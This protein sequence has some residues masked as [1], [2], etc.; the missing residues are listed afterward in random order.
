MNP[1]LRHYKSAAYAM[2]V[3]VCL[4]MNVRADGITIRDVETWLDQER[5]YLNARANCEFSE[6]SIVALNHGVAIHIL[7]DIKTKQRRKFLWDKTL[8]TS[9]I[10]YKIEYHPLS[11][12]YVLTELNRY[13]RAD[14]QY[15]NNALEKLGVI[16]KWPLISKSDLNPD[17]DYKIHIRARLDIDALPA[18]LRPMAFISKNWR[19]DSDWQQWDFRL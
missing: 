1:L 18:P 19:L 5:Y 6:E 11:E 12:R 10:A 14:F 15:L 16:E 17:H 2:I 7:I 13:H 3:L 8:H 4:A 9:T